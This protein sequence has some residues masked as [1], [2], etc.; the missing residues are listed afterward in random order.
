[1]DRAIFTDIATSDYIR[2][3]LASMFNVQ[4]RK[5]SKILIF[6]AS[7]RATGHMQHAKFVQRLKMIREIRGETHFLLWSADQ[8]YSD[9]RNETEWE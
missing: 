3:A 8:P 1:M 4:I 9:L 6:S 7:L 2:H 5:S